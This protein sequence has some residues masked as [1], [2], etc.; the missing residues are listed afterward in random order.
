MTFF[1]RILSFLLWLLIISWALALIKRFG[2]WMSRQ[3]RGKPDSQ[4]D[5]MHDRSRARRLVRDPVCGTHVAEVLAL[6]VREGNEVL[7][8]CSAECRAR[9]L[10]ETQRKVANG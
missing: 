8:F 4:E 1:A 10:S 6:P 5:E 7:H 2:V 9:Y 3:S